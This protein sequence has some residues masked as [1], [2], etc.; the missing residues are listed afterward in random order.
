V[1][2]GV[3]PAWLGAVTALAPSAFVA[4]A[5]V[6]AALPWRQLR[7]AVATVPLA[8]A[9]SDLLIIPTLSDGH[10]GRVLAR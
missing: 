7:G 3:L 6:T 1:L 2:E 5:I 10:R 4:A 8:V 9:S